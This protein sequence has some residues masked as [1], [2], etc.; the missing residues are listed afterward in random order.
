MP[1]RNT[2]IRF[3]SKGNLLPAVRGQVKS[4]LRPALCPDVLQMLGAGVIGIRVRIGGSMNTEENTFTPGQ[5]TVQY[6][7]GTPVIG[8]VQRGKKIFGRGTGDYTVMRAQG[9][10]EQRL[11]T[12]IMR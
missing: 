6:G 8:I 4:T 12:G 7:A 3:E 10:R 11:L 5:C 2:I 1:S 9:S